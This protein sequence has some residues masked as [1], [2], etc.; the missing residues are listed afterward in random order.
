MGR[1]D[2]GRE[3]LVIVRDRRCGR[4]GSAL[5]VAVAAAGLVLA[6]GP[7][8]APEREQP[9]K[10]RIDT[11]VWNSE[12]QVF[13]LSH[14]LMF[15]SAVGGDAAGF[16]LITRAELVGVGTIGPV[17][18]PVVLRDVDGGGVRRTDGVVLLYSSL[19]GGSAGGPVEVVVT[20]QLVNPGGRAVHEATV[21]RL[22]TLGTTSVEPG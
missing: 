9:E 1:P 6:A 5:A 7:A 14:R 11:V 17:E 21:R 10:V 8:Y 12:A 2:R 15:G 13:E 18:T 19:P 22:M 4:L 16:V 3:F 20:T